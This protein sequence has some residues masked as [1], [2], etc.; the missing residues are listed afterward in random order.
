MNTAHRSTP[1]AAQ[2]LA[3]PAPATLLPPGQSL[4]LGSQLVRRFR[5]SAF[6]VAPAAGQALMLK[7]TAGAVWLTWPGC[8]EDRYV[9]AGHTLLLPTDAA[10][11][12]GLLIEAEPRL[13][14][15]A[16]Q[17]SLLLLGEVVNEVVGEET[18]E[19]TGQ[20]AGGRSGQAARI[21]S[22]PS[23]PNNPILSLRQTLPKRLA[24]L[25]RWWPSSAPAQ[26][27]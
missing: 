3:A 27:G 1:Q 13:A 4:R 24:A 19:Q 23:C 6:S 9:Q 14:P 15:G 12:A 16:A 7:V 11:L 21:D 18:G 8:G 5:P 20:A 17:L 22:A 26:L 25:R 10:A 2:L